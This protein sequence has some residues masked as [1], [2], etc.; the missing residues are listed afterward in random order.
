MKINITKKEYQLFLDMVYLSDWVL[1]AHSEKRTEE[2]KPYKKYGE[3]AILQMSISER[4]EKEMAFH[5]EYHEEFDKNGLDN[6][7]IH[8]L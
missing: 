6:L 7:R 2:K 4:F 5:Q 8:N 1:H 3:E